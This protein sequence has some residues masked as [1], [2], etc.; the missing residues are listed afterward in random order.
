M[1]AEQHVLGYKIE[2]SL[3]RMFV[4]YKVGYD[5]KGLPIYQ[6]DVVHVAELSE[7][8]ESYVISGLEPDTP[9]YVR[10]TAYNRVG[11]TS[12]IIGPIWTKK[13]TFSSTRGVVWYEPLDG[14]VWA[15]WK[16]TGTPDYTE[17][18]YTNIAVI[19]D[20]HTVVV[21]NT[22]L[23]SFALDPGT[24]LFQIKSCNDKGSGGQGCGSIDDYIVVVPRRVWSET[25]DAFGMKEKVRSPKGV[26]IREEDDLL[27]RSAA[28]IPPRSALRVRP[29]ELIPADGFIKTTNRSVIREIFD[30]TFLSDHA[31]IPFNRILTS[32]I[33]RLP[34]QDASRTILY[35]N[36]TIA[37]ENVTAIP[38]R[39]LG[40]FRMEFYLTE[41]DHLSMKESAPCK[42][43][44]PVQK[45]DRFYF[46]GMPRPTVP[47]ILREKEYLPSRDI[48]RKVPP[49]Y[50]KAKQW[51]D[52]AEENKDQ[53]VILKI[54]DGS[55]PDN[56]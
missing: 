24:Y 37:V 46:R 26:R 6:N 11:S 4:P 43:G 50:V 41:I 10:V 8:A 52:F 33:D 44:T 36:V 38:D 40:K 16:S 28:A 3:S 42:T 1:A 17:I 14:L 25:T 19:A 29:E 22:T 53:E 30:C 56:P 39:T 45:T 47:E 54:I 5:E 34:V 18:T 32:V 23:W 48:P 12:K 20:I 9:Y 2:V 15:D 13:D 55:D 21:Y 31:K 7:Y 35:E 49:L 51:V 27:I